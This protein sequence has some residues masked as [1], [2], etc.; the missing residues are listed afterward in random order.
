MRETV[1]FFIEKVRLLIPECGGREIEA[2]TSDASGVLSLQQFLSVA[3]KSSGEP[4]AK[5]RRV[6]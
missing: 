6:S 5:R 2:H 1:D 3:L 4:A